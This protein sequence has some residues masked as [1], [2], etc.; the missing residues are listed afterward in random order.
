M[1]RFG[2]VVHTFYWNLFIGGRS[3]RGVFLF[4]R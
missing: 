1:K 3:S 4:S 2:L